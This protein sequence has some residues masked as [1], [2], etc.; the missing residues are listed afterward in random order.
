MPTGKITDDGELEITSGSSGV[1]STLSLD[2]ANSYK[3]DAEAAGAGNAN[4][5]MI[6]ANKT[7]ASGSNEGNTVNVNK[8]ATFNV[9]GANTS[10][11]PLTMNIADSLS[12]L[13]DNVTAASVVPNLAGMVRAVLT[14]SATAGNVTVNISKDS[15][16]ALE[17]DTSGGNATVNNSGLMTSVDQTTTENT[18]VRNLAGGKVDIS[19]IN[20]ATPT[21]SLSGAGNAELGNKELPPGNLHLGDTASGTISGNDGSPVKIGDSTLT[22]TGD[23]TYIGTTDANEGV[24]P[25]NG[26]RSVA[27]G[28]VTMKPGVA[29]GGN[30]AIGGVVDMLDDAH[31]ITG[32]A[33]DSMGKLTTGPL[34]S[35]GNAQ[36]DHRFG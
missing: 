21:D 7:G 2:R 27:T 36:L 3:D 31:I 12:T 4:N 19:T 1:G 10:L 34:T 32:A 24:L 18:A 17:E 15:I 23:N 14:N 20:G 25:I 16:L 13:V 5:M 28:Q 30:G 11:E 29:L 33:I 35:S 22:L 8:G 6:N 26:N 9:N